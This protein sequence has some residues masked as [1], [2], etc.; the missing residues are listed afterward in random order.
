MR[1][2][3]EK[4]PV[5]MTYLPETLKF[6]NEHGTGMLKLIC[7]ELEKM[8]GKPSNSNATFKDIAKELV[9][10][11]HSELWFYFYCSKNPF[12]G[13]DVISHANKYVCINYNTRFH[14]AGS[15]N[16]VDWVANFFH[17][18]THLADQSSPFSFGHKNQKDENAAPMVVG[19][20][21]RIVYKE[22][23]GKWL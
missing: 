11:Y 20:I 12:I 5:K 1:I 4:I 15:F 10:F 19:R 13:H 14:G 18:L 22:N 23:I 6:L 8:D 2:K 3:S 17:E 7:L 9:S 16:V 21:A